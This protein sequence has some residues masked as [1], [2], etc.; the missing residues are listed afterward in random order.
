MTIGEKN[1]TI[2][3]KRLHIEPFGRKLKQ[4]LVLANMSQTTL[5]EE[6]G[7]SDS[8]ISSMKNGKRL[9]GEGARERVLKI[10]KPYY[11]LIFLFN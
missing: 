2:G 7:I 1:L 10:I 4:Y 6:T 8:I 3:K 5:A 11:D 9:T